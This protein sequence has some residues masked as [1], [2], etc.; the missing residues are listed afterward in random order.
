[1][2]P[3]LHSIFVFLDIQLLAILETLANRLILKEEL[4]L[5]QQNK[6]SSC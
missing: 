4:Q 1:M 6:N 3:V 2:M 5:H